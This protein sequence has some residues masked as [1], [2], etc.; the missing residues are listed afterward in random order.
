M[1]KVFRILPLLIALGWLS[2]CGGDAPR[3]GERIR[4]FTEGMRWQPGFVPFY[5]DEA[6][7]RVYLLIDEA[8]FV[9]A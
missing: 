6:T 5:A 2:A 1:L 9:R 8:S 4:E 7:G 3:G